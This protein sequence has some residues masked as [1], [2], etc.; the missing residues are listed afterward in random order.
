[1]TQ[2]EVHEVDYHINMALIPIVKTAEQ[3]TDATAEKRCH[4]LHVSIGIAQVDLIL[5]TTLL[6]G[7]CSTSESGNKVSICPCRIAC[8][9]LL[10]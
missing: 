5:V 1:M 6:V 7:G 10:R 3:S 9:L 8:M 4:L 2:S